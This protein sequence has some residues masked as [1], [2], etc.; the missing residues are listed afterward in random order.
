[1]K[2]TF[3]DRLSG[4]FENPIRP[5][6]YKSL[7]ADLKPTETPLYGLVMYNFII[8]NKQVDYV[9][10]IGTAG[11]FSAICAVKALEDVGRS[12]KVLTI[13]IKKR[14]YRGST[15]MK[16]VQKYTQY[17]RN[18]I[19]LE[20]LTGDSKSVLDNISGQPNLVF[21][22]GHHE[23][24]SVSAEINKIKS[25]S[26]NETIHIFDDCHIKT[27]NYFLKLYPN[28]LSDIFS[29]FPIIRRYL[30]GNTR[31]YQ[32]WIAYVK[33]PGVIEAVKQFAEDHDSHIHVITDESHAPVTFVKI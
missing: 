18:D 3:Y 22:D 25:K 16:N 33:Y 29:K 1:M 4:Y 23:Y 28:G 13:D 5:T 9:I 32:I 15:A 27:P 8:N 24:S 2:I 14:D 30:S 17:D 12:G 20:F 21:Y 10:D 26:G 6:W 31:L 7:V 11:G 19:C